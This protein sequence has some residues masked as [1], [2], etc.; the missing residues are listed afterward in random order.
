[1]F[2]CSKE[3]LQNAVVFLQSWGLKPRVPKDIFK[4]NHL[5]SSPHANRMKQLKQALLATDSK[6]VWC[7]RGGYGSLRLAPEL[8]RMRAPKHTKLF[9]GLS[10]ISTL[11]L[12]L[13]QNWNWPTVHG[14]LLDRL[15][16]GKTVPRFARELKS[17]VFGEEKE[18]RFAKLK[19]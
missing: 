1:G 7:L 5:F 11:H 16:K 4:K 15:G 17:F 13:N 14:P 2:A 6:A 9:I 19:P 18:I 8:V 10:D 3:D 12:F